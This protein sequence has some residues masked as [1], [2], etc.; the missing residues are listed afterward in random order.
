MSVDRR[1]PGL[2]VTGTDT[3]VG[4]TWVAAAIA[5]IM[6]GQGYR[7]GVLKP[8]A[9]GAIRTEDGLCSE[10]GEVLKAAVGGEVP[11]SRVVPI[12]FE[13]PLAPPVAARRQG[14]R[15]GW[16]E[17]VEATKK[18]LDWWS[19][20]VDVMV[21]E[22]IGGILCPIADGASVADLALA[23]DY[24]S[25]IVARRGLGTIN[26]TLLTVE[27]ARWRGLR[28]A[29]VV[30][31]AAGPTTDPIAEATNGEEL[32]RR[33][34]GVGLLAET[35]RRGAPSDLGMDLGGVDWYGWARPQRGA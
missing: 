20:R 10:D 7:V 11:D 32:A 16:E 31:N 17:I 1:V 21:V 4:K 35:A 23:L 18:A 30:L 5:Q 2:F 27:A 8:V 14:R 24:P 28:I 3:G 9:T 22:G 15:L 26:Q 13:E 25:V 29:G 19:D 33:L 12:I 6:S 34:G